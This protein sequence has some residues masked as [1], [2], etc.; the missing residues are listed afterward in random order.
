M[1]KLRVN[2][3]KQRI[4]LLGGAAAL[5]CALQYNDLFAGGTVFLFVCILTEVTWQDLKEMKISDRYIGMVLFVSG[6]SFFTNPL[7]ISAS[8]RGIG[9]VCV[10]VPM[11][12]T[13]LVSPGTLGGGDIKLMAGCGLFLGW[14]RT[15]LAAVLA[16]VC[17]AF[18]GL[19]MMIVKKKDRKTHIAFGP[20]L[21]L[22]M[23]AVLLCGDWLRTLLF[24]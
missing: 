21:S 12:L 2:Q 5:A 4:Y 18:Y 13:A 16:V 11:L 3:R 7:L 15:L 24:R 19:G 17:G 23:T 22:G 8:E 14:E 20:F 10:S 9:A 6:V 1:K